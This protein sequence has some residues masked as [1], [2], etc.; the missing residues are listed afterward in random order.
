MDRRCRAAVRVDDS[1]LPAEPALP[2][3][4]I[5]VDNGFGTGCLLN[6]LLILPHFLCCDHSRCCVRS[7]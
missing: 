4:A 3:H 5:G 6:H 7:L 2:V 1:A